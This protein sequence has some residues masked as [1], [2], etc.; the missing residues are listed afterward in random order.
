LEI[1][2]K[3]TNKDFIKKSKGIW[4]KIIKVNKIRLRNEFNNTTDKGTLHIIYTNKI[5]CYILKEIL[6]KSKEIIKNNKELAIDYLKGIIAAEGNINIKKQTRCIYM[7]RISAKEEKEREFYKELLEKIGI[8]ITCKDMKTI[9][10]EEGKKL[11]WKTDKGRAGC[12]IISRW[13]NF[14]KIFRLN[15]LELNKRKQKLFLNYFINNK[16]TKQLLDFD[17]FINKKF[18]M[19]E[20]Q[21]IFKFKGRYVNRLKTLER[22]NLVNKEFIKNVGKNKTYSY[23]LNNNYLEIY[24]KLNRNNMTPFTQSFL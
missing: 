1:C 13:D 22:L 20:A 15:L 17:Y 8:K 14:L 19:K 23:N 4:N 10:K 7:I 6:D 24:N 11:G 12:V 18:R 3:N 21:K 16:F 2:T 9:S 5:F